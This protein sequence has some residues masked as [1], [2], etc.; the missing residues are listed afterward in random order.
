MGV[1]LL[2]IRQQEVAEEVWALQHPAYRIEAAL[3]GVAD[4]PPLQDTIQSLQA[5]GE[6][7]W[8]YR[9]QDGELIGA[10]SYEREKSGYYTI[11]RLMV[12]PDCLRQGIG[13]TLMEHLLSELPPSTFW[14]VTAEVRNMPAIILYERFGFVRYETF[15]PIPGIEMLQL[16]RAPVKV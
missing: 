10:I 11:C 2:D 1:I 3:I 15:K 7:F 4:L 14:T 6:S 5:C 16:K 12:H 8:G 9:N 13:S